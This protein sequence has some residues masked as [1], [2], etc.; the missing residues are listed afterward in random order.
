M[1]RGIV[2]PYTNWVD[3]AYTANSSYQDIDV[4]GTGAAGATMVQLFLDTNASSNPTVGIRKNGSTQDILFDVAAE[5]SAAYVWVALDANG[6]F[7]LKS[8]EAIANVYLIAETDSDVV[9]LDPWVDVSPTAGSWQTINSASVPDTAVAVMN[10]LINTST[11]TILQVAVRHGDSTDARQANWDL[12]IKGGTS[13]VTGLN[14]SGEFDGFREA[15]TGRI[16]VTGYSA[17]GATGHTNVANATNV[18]QATTGAWTDLDL[19]ANT[20]ATADYVIIEMTSV[21][22]NTN[23]LLRE[24]GSTLDLTSSGTPWVIAGQTRVLV[25]SMDVAQVLEYYIDTANL[26]F[27]IRGYGGP[28]A[29]GAQTITS[30]EAIALS[31]IMSAPARWRYSTTNTLALSETISFKQFLFIT[32]TEIVSLSDSIVATLKR[33]LISALETISLVE[34][35]AVRFLRGVI[36][37]LE[38]ITLV[39]T[40]SLAIKRFTVAVSETIALVDSITA[41]LKRR[42]IQASE[43]IALVE[44]SAV[45]LIRRTLTALESISLQ[46][47]FSI[48]KIGEAVSIAIIETLALVESVTT[49]VPRYILSK[50]DSIVL[51]SSTSVQEITIAIP[52]TEE[53][54]FPWWKIW[55]RPKIVKI[56]VWNGFDWKPLRLKM[57]INKDW[58]DKTI[59]VYDGRNWI[60]VN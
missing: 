57:Y 27:Y 8:D 30:T 58:Q 52:P 31:Q 40:A 55:A 33:H 42:I 41:T 37:K 23:A 15:T 11:T 51:E 4:S 56:N 3:I 29:A 34:S 18:S 17:A 46:E 36:T 39:E 12:D 24:N 21:G 14:V 32:A 35:F 22:V 60:V 7:E 47:S 26:D 9:G 49:F 53:G 5:S 54:G 43:T 1:A 20:S 38:S 25:V 59:K 44:S 2:K 19:T 16:Y 45:S 6:I 50:I 13:A 10:H 28:E 48:T